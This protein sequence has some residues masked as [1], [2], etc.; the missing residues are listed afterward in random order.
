MDLI[1]LIKAWLDLTNRHMAGE[2]VDSKDIR[3][4]KND[5][6]RLVAY[7]TG[8][9]S[10]AVSEEIYQDV[11]SFCEAMRNEDINMK[12]LG[13]NQMTKEAAL[14]IYKKIYMFSAQ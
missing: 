12:Q 9:E 13:L 5:V 8:N 2:S 4:H 6:F 11:I 3:K 14:A 1:V 7:I 10:V